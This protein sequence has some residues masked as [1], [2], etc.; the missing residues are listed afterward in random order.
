MAAAVVVVVAALAGVLLAARPSAGS[1]TAAAVT[2]TPSPSA[3]SHAPR[4]GL[5]DGHGMGGG[6]G[7]VTG[8]DGSTLTLRTLRGT[9]TVDTTSSTTY[10]KEGKSIALKDVKVDDIVQVRPV[11]PSG[12]STPP[13][14]PPTTVTAQSITVVLPKLFGRVESISG[15]TI[16]IV[17]RDG[18]IA[19][20]YTTSS[21]TYTMDG[22]SSSFSAVKAGEYIM[23]EGTQT[24]LKHLTADRVVISTNAG[25]GPGGGFF[26]RAHGNP[27]AP[28]SAGATPAGIGA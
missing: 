21:T 27:W 26:G 7:T 10:S 16:F 3:H 15:P 25:P 23:A 17:T 5:F 8:I 28:A 9:L 12:A 2:S 11:H 4:G 6:T 24:D 18:Q 14:S 13:A 19:Y 1:A 20:I 22:N